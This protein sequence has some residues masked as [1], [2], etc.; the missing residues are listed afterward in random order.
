MQ[1]Y[2]EAD[3]KFSLIL[4]TWLHFFI[5]DVSDMG[6]SAV[7]YSIST[8]QT[9]RPLS[10]K[11]SSNQTDLSPKQY[12]SFTNVESDLQY[13]SIDMEFVIINLFTDTV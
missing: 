7:A 5:N 12:T 8:T 13:E 1:T 4:A 2:A 6:L 9:G 11:V 3:I 10:D